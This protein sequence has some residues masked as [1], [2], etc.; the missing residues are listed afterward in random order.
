MDNNITHVIGCQHTLLTG[1]NK[2]KPCGH[3]IICE[4]H[5]MCEK[6]NNM[7]IAK[8]YKTY[9]NYGNPDQAE[10]WVKWINSVDDKK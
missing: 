6:H 2:D 1:K 3:K 8:N 5:K 10:L 9:N 7:R 4:T